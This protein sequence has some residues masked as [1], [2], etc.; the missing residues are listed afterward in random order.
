MLDVRYVDVDPFSSIPFVRIRNTTKTAVLH[1]VPIFPGSGAFNIHAVA[2][3]IACSTD[4]AD[5]AP[6]DTGPKDVI[7]ADLQAQG[8][9]FSHAKEKFKFW[10]TWYGIFY[11]EY[12]HEAIKLLMEFD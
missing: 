1:F 6:L 7:V 5:V 9:G 11:G 4:S 2:A 10:K 12:S 3:G 8:F